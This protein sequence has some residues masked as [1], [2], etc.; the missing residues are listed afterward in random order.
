VRSKAHTGPTWFV[1]NAVQIVQL[2][3]TP[4]VIQNLL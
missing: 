3:R 2:G 1:L 4:D